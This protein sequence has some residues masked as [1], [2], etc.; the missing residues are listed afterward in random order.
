MTEA[1]GINLA[2]YAGMG[3]VALRGRQEETAAL[4]DATI[5]DVACEARV[6]G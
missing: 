1:T 3:L 2:P 6:T 5:V 4:V